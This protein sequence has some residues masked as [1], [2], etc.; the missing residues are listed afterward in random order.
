MSTS[1]STYILLFTFLQSLVHH[2]SDTSLFAHTSTRKVQ[3]S[4]PTSKLYSIFKMGLRSTFKGLATKFQSRREISKK[5]VDTSAYDEPSTPVAPR[6]RILSDEFT[7]LPN[8]KNSKY[9]TGSVVSPPK[10]SKLPRFLVRAS[11]NAPRPFSTTKESKTE[12]LSNQATTTNTTVEEEEEIVGQV[13]PTYAG[14]AIASPNTKA[15]SEDGVEP[16]DVDSE[17]LQRKMDEFEDTIQPLLL[18]K[19]PQ[20]EV[21]EEVNRQHP[22]RKRRSC[23][24]VLEASGRASFHSVFDPNVIDTAFVSTPTAPVFSSTPLRAARAGKSEAVPTTF[25]FSKTNFEGANTD[26]AQSVFSDTDDESNGCHSLVE[27]SFES[28]EEVESVW[29]CPARIASAWFNAVLEKQR[30]AHRVEALE[31]EKEAGLE[32]IQQ[33]R[34]Y[35]AGLA[36]RLS[37]Q[38][39]ALYA[40]A[41]DTHVLRE[42]IAHLRT[43]SQVQ[44]AR[45]D[46]TLEASRTS[47]GILHHAYRLIEGLTEQNSALRSDLEESRAREG[48]KDITI[49]EVRSDFLAQVQEFESVNLLLQQEKESSEESEGQWK[50]A[51]DRQAEELEETEEELRK[52]NQEVD[53]LLDQLVAHENESEISNEDDPPPSGNGQGSS[54]ASGL[55]RKAT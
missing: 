37:V 8:S 22:Q 31:A 12:I 23:V 4:T 51:Y 5:V 48:A 20:T 40:Y 15:V 11:K 13:M 50:R 1:T 43:R 46:Q 27:A 21:D 53:S 35:G 24:S 25:T 10:K 36:D 52:A 44:Q 55:H 49:S 30:L 47:E 39:D 18:S 26:T 14:T 45:L 28:D 3:A 32:F 2:F 54:A 29:T 41:Y 19:R 7:P 9:S 34:E 42:T 17:S 6:L 38:N 33:V 16:T